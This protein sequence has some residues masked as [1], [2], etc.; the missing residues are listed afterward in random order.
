MLARNFSVLKR[1][2]S[3]AP[4]FSAEAEDGPAGIF[5]AQRAGHDPTLS[6]YPV[7]VNSKERPLYDPFTLLYYRL[8]IPHF[9]RNRRLEIVAVNS[10]VADW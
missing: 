1:G 3:V 10:F 4:K 8:G 9:I 7:S 6:R 5:D 2:E